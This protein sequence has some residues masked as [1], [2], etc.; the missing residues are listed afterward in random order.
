MKKVFGGRYEIIEKIGSGGMADVYKAYDEV[1]HRTVAL[2]ILH[3]QFA[4]E[5]N[6]VAR[7]RRE[8]QAAA[9]LN[10]PNIVNVHDWGSEDG[11]YFIVMEYLEG[12]NLKQII[13]DRGSLPFDI[14][15]DIARQVCS[16]LRFAHKHDIIH[17]DI[18]PHNII[19]TT[20]GEVKVTDFGIARAG[21]STMTQTGTILGTAH[22]ISPEQA[23][24][25][26]ATIASDIYSLGV[27]L[28]EMLTG[29]APFEGESPVAIALKHA[30]ESPPSPRSIN[31]DIPESLEAVVLKALS[32]HPSDRYQS[33]Q[34]MREDLVRCAQGLPVKATVTPSE[35]ETIVLPRP[36]PPPVEKEVRRRRWIAWA[37][38]IL[39]ILL[40]FSL[41]AAWGFYALAPRVVV[42]DL[43]DK[44][45]S[46]AKQILTRKG[47]KL[48]VAEWRYSDTI[49]SGGIIDQYPSPGRKV[50]EGETIKV[51]ASKGKRLISV[52]EV[53]GRTEAQA[54]YLLAKAGL[55]VGEI[56]RRH[57]NKIPED[58]VI[59]QDP[60]GDK[61]V[62][63]GTKVNLIVSLG[64]EM[65]EVPDV[66]N[67]TE[68]EAA[69]LISQAK[70]KMT[71]T[72]ESSDEVEKGRIIRQSP[73]PGIEVKRGAVVKVVVST[74]PRMVTVPDVVG[75]DESAAE[76]ELENLGFIVVIKEGVS[77]P[78]DWG[79][80]VAQ[81]PKGGEQVKRGSTITIWVGEEPSG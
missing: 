35:G 65:V 42:P 7:F 33:A 44:T 6:F 54:T 1:L 9:G 37:V 62:T 73:Q 70:L 45:I 11:T 76:S 5:E 79:K 53:V 68:E 19:I 16:A 74:G 57:H 20:E 26:P 22:Y 56:E 60:K 47:L 61:K 59:D 51:T 50:R 77:S 78:E 64:I 75:K 2:K 48:K 18:K 72:E 14:A 52:P 80:V 10:H 17:R 21:T 36:V 31:P 30:H 34:E 63:K 49:A 58:R 81:S 8:A 55:E 71:R 13:A 12:R 41:A 67:R 23:H 46:Q 28:F 27:V 4:Q 25:A 15:V 24:G 38:W 32:K 66:I 43:E 29:K 69:A 3:P 39:A 40:A